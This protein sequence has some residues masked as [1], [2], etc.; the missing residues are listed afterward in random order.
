MPRIKRVTP[1]TQQSG[2]ANRNTKARMVKRRQIN[3]Q[4]AAAPPPP[5]GGAR[6]PTNYRGG[7]TGF[8]PA[9]TQRPPGS[10]G[11]MGPPGLPRPAAPSVPLP[12][13][14]SGL[15]TPMPGPF[16]QAT[17]QRQVNYPAPPAPPASR[18]PAMP[19]PGKRRT[20]R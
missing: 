4:I 9:P 16:K 8:N 7:P 18:G 10:P 15:P 12:G 3:K 19:L 11:V 13:P 20:P 2:D 17:P 6:P 1:V 14:P 5:M